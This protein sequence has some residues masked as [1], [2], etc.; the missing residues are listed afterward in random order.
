MSTSQA[1][2]GHRRPTTSVSATNVSP[3]RSIMLIGVSLA[4]TA[5]TAGMGVRRSPD[6]AGPGFTPENP[7][8]YLRALKEPPKWT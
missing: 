8:R 7:A 4:E 2:F 1:F 5:E 3:R 6:S